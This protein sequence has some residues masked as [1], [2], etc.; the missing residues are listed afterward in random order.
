M[1]IMYEEVHDMRMECLAAVGMAFQGG[2]KAV[3]GVLALNYFRDDFRCLAAM[4]YFCIANGAIAGNR[5][6]E[7][8]SRGETPAVHSE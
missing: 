6:D 4:F 1:L 8:L 2:G 7:P 3:A 5:Q